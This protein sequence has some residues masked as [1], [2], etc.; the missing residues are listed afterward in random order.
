MFNN[1]TNLILL[2]FDK[3]LLVLC[4]FASKS[5]H[6]IIRRHLFYKIFGGHNI[7]KSLEPNVR[8]FNNLIFTSQT[9]AAPLISKEC[10]LLKAYQL[11][12]TFTSTRA[13]VVDT[14]YLTKTRQAGRQ[15]RQAELVDVPTISSNIFAA[16]TNRTN[17]AKQ[18]RI[19]G[20]LNILTKICILAVR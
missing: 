18:G 3:T 6:Q 15:G 10:R 4:P 19:G 20:P 8:L 12:Q 2:F 9:G 5:L 17:T 16:A 7:M 11:T 14:N 1:S 13:L